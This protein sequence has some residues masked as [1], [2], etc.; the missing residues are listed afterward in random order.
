MLMPGG[1]AVFGGGGLGV[2]DTGAEPSAGP[3]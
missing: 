1:D 3:A 2:V